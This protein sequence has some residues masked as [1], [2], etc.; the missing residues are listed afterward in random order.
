MNV[1]PALLASTG[2][3]RVA[4]PGPSRLCRIGRA[5][6]D[7]LALISRFASAQREQ[8]Q[9]LPDSVQVSPSLELREALFESPLR[10]WAWIAREGDD[11]IGYAFA[12]VG[13]GLLDDGYYLRL[14]AMHVELRWRQRGVEMQLLEAARATAVELGCRSVQW[15]DGAHMPRVSAPGVVYRHAASHSLPLDSAIA[16]A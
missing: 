16:C 6:P 13:Y 9:G 11:A 12:T 10:A 4:Y 8:A 2:M 15:Q 7:D 3:P 14:E 5:R 1:F